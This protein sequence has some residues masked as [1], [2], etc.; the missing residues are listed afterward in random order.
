MSI[1]ER[2]VHEDVRAMLMA[3]ENFQYAH[4]IKFERP[5]RP[6]S[7][8]GRVSTSAVR[9]TYMTDASRDVN[10][11]DGSINLQG[12]A[13]GSQVYL[14]NKVLG[15][16]NIQES[17]EARADTCSITLDGNGIGGA[18]TVVA[19]VVQVNPTTWDLVLYSANPDL[20]EA[21]FREG[22][23]ITLSGDRVGSF[24]IQK[25]RSNGIRITK[26][27]DD[28]AVGAGLNLSILLNS[29]EIKS[30]LLNK[31]AIDYSSFINREVH[32]YRAYFV[33]G[34]LVGGYRNLVKSSIFTDSILWGRSKTGVKLTSSKFVEGGVIGP[35]KQ[36]TSYSLSFKAKVLG[37]N[38]INLSIDLFPDSL[39][40]TEVTVTTNSTLFKWENISSSNLDMTSKDL[41]LRFFKGDGIPEGV[42]IEITDIMLTES[43][44]VSSW[45]SPDSPVGPILLFRG[46]INNVSF[47]DDDSG[48]KV[49]WGLTSHWGDFSQVRGRITSDEFHR[50]LDQ[51]GIPQPY[52]AIKPIYAY[53]KGF[54][55]SDTS[56][57]LL[58]TYQVLVEKTAVKAKNGFFG[59]GAKTKVKTT[60]VPEDRQTP[61]DFQLQSKALPVIYG[62]RNMTG[63]PIFADTLKSNSSE[64]YVVYAL[65]EGQ[66]GGIYDVY[67]DGKSLIC[68]NKEDFDTRSSQNAEGSIDVVCRGRADRGDVLGGVTVTNNNSVNYYY[69][70]SLNIDLRDVWNQ[71]FNRNAITTYYEYIPPTGV[72]AADTIGKGVIHGETISMTSPQTI[73]LDFFSGTE[74][75]K[76]A[77]QLVQLAQSS[78]FKVQN[79]YWTGTDTSEYWGPNHRLID[80]AYIVAKFKIKEGETT[81]P[82]LEYIV[83]GKVLACYNYDYSYA[84]DDK[85]SDENPHHFELGDMVTLSTNQNVQIID[86]WSFVRP[87]GVLE[88]RFRYSEPPN[89]GYIDGVPTTTRFSM[90]KDTHTWTMTTFNWVAHSGTVG[91]AISAPVTSVAEVGKGVTVNFPNNPSLTIGG[92]PSQQSPILSVMEDNNQ[93]F[94]NAL[95]SGRVYSDRIETDMI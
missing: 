23:K 84:H 79:D 8:S 50:A 29:E 92:D 1:S 39:P 89:L 82:D 73:T 11:D 59:I 25:F 36:N 70:P 53:D 5:S 63:L 48:I 27:D 38:Q 19:E 9:Y 2:V 30:I 55:H 26:I 78:S 65:S 4:L 54:N 45:V 17:V 85:M 83:R 57:N 34:K 37:I 12:S 80:T 10:F 3:N 68:N 22:D 58:S 91:A 67:V 87:D 47:D 15:V 72:T 60:M 76:A 88:Y 14:A 64:V 16:S 86:K 71:V 41:Y 90:S 62:V 28:L 44:S 94:R 69:D 93:V 13:N 74:S 95:L 20:V 32:I 31:N 75:Q 43:S 56:I 33:D 24:N 52:S 81:I 42:S 35:L 66:I 61:L 51:N 49:Q 7:L 46:I 21:G 40:E 77:S 6:D 18:A